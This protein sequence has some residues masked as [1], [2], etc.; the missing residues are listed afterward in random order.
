MDA[1]SIPN[2]A[3][4]YRIVHVA[5]GRMYIGSAMNLHIRRKNHFN[6]LRNNKHKNPKLQRAFNKYGPDAFRFEVL[7]YVLVPELLT[8]REEYWFSKLR[9]FD[10]RGFNISP[11]A[12]SNLGVKYTPE[13]VEKSRVARTGKKSTP[14]QCENIGASRRGKPSTNLGRKAS[15]AT[16]EKLRNSH[17]GKTLSEEQ[18]RKVGDA[19]RGS[20]RSPEAIEKTR[21]ANTGRK[22]SPE[23]IARMSTAQKG[24]KGDYSEAHARLMKTYIVTSPDGTT[25]M[26][27]GLSKFCSEHQL[28]ASNL[29]QVA[30]G[31]V[32]QANG[33]TAHYL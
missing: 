30:Q 12:G 14:E 10:S 21:Q 2:A 6:T 4:I 31:K 27:H 18:K 3:G 9:P 23:A 7:E 5:T 1:N 22:N 17:L 33:W 26:V 24:R 20:K 8:A 19:H 28:N 15:E 32:L 16:R 29:I 11:I 25:Y 13:A